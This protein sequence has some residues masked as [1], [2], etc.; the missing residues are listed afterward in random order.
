MS[1]KSDENIAV[2]ANTQK[3]MQR[4][5]AEIKKTVT[6]SYVTKEEFEPIKK[7]YYLLLSLLI[8]S[9][10]GAGLALILK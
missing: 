4:D 3:Y 9:V 1:L 5:I 6:Q 10:V 7:G 8:T 2:I